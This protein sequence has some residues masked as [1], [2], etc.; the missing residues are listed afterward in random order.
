MI[1]F[2]DVTKKYGNSDPVL[3]QVSFV[4]DRGSFVYLI[5]PTGSGKTTIFRLIIRDLLPS[6]GEI[7]IGEWDLLTLPKSKIPN[8][9]SGEVA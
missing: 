7:S 9:K 3:D 5:G 6:V 2:N 8:L 4:I 1:K